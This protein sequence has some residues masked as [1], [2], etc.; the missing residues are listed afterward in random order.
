M[1]ADPSAGDLEG[2]PA[3]L[4]LPVPRMGTVTRCR[5]L[6]DPALRK[7]IAD[8]HPW[9]AHMASYT[10]G[11]SDADGNPLEG[12][13]G[14]SL[15]PAL[16]VLCAEAA[17]GTAADGVPGAVAVE[18]VHA[19]SLVHDDVIDSDDK[20]RHR[21]AAWKAFGVGPAVLSGDALLALAIKEL[22]PH[23]A[24]LAHLSHALV[25]L[26]NGQTADMVFEER[27]WTGPGAVTA[28]EYADMAE[29][30]TGA[31][32]GCAAAIGVTLGGASRAVADRMYGMGRD[33][34]LAF[35]M[36][37]D[38]LGVWGDPADTGKPAHSDLRRG[39]KTL[40]VISAL[41]A[42][43]PAARELA[44][45]LAS[46]RRDEEYVR[47]AARLIEEAGGRRLTLERAA[48]HARLAADAIRACYPQAAELLGLSELFV[49]RTH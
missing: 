5:R 7:S 24:A 23:P 37:D 45:L 3:A 19:F 1:I 48:H 26:V 46:G 31:L 41:T 32:L 43:H 34:G 11:W 25:E 16:V 9:A 4:T 20:R 8:L 2:M 39:K 49:N 13:P 30:K 10:F 42:D 6:I 12:S 28:E 17:G 29:R 36:A 38:L 47:R 22:A 21:D 18:L 15:R 27:P 33:L 35:Q 40:P 14:K 44:G